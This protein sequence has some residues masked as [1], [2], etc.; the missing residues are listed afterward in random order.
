MESGQPQL[1]VELQTT[2]EPF[3]TPIERRTRAPVRWF[4]R[5]RHPFRLMLRTL[6]ELGLTPASRSKVA[7]VQPEA[8]DA[9]NP[10]AA[11]LRPPVAN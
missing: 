2:E 5:Q 6:T 7:P 9:A 4:E 8:P 11:L 1:Q 3:A 10:L